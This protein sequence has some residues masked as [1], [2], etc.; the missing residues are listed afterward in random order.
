MAIMEP[1]TGRIVGIN[2]GCAQLFGFGL[3]T[4]PGRAASDREIQR[5]S[6]ELARLAAAIERAGTVCDLATTFCHRD[7]TALNLRCAG[8]AV[9]IG[10]KRFLYL[11]FRRESPGQSDGEPLT[12][13]ARKQRLELLGTFACG[14]AHDFNNLL[15]VINL[16]LELASGETGDAMGKRLVDLRKATERASELTRHILGFCREEQ[17]ERRPIQLQSVTA[18]TLRMFRP[19][20]PQ[21]VV[22]EA[23]IDPL[24]PKVLANGCQFQ[25]VLMN[26]LVNAAHAMENRS[27]RLTVGFDTAELENPAFAAFPGLRSGLYVRITVGDTGCGMSAET[28]RQIF[29]PFFTTKRGGGSGLGLAMVQHIVKCHEGAITVQSSPGLGTTF[30]VYLPA[31]REE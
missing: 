2:A 7:G 1:G 19:N 26:L 25:Q 3:E 21:A 27:G 28:V 29:N 16:N 24:A 11:Q 18:E 4:V 20:L 10:G 6:D 23:R 31:H 13:Q 5:N 12:K 30:T 22:V 14:V 17:P 8:E 15:A 9:Q